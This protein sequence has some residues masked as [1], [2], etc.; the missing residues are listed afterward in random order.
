MVVAGSHYILAEN[1]V[2]SYF[3]SAKKQNIL[4]TF[5]ALWWEVGGFAFRPAQPVGVLSCLKKNSYLATDAIVYAPNFQLLYHLPRC[6]LCPNGARWAYSVYQSRIW[7]LGRRF[8]WYRFCLLL[9]HSAHLNTQ[10]VQLEK[11]HIL[12]VKL[13]PNGG[14]TARWSKRLYWEVWGSRR[15]GFQLVPALAAQLTSNR[16]Q[17]GCI[18]IAT[19]LA[20]KFVWLLSGL[21]PQICELFLLTEFLLNFHQ[22]LLAQH[23]A[24]VKIIIS[25][26]FLGKTLTGVLYCLDRLGHVLSFD[27]KS[28][29]Q[30]SRKP[31]DLESQNFKIF[32]WTSIPT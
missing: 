6:V 7:M 1:Y 27:A 18:K 8:D 19:L 15:V 31:F 22:P 28:A 2:T 9:P 23:C 3:W 13:R 29:P 24:K 20:A 25:R 30:I 21:S 12:Q 11:G 14:R 32:A 26:P 17:I 5:V 16:P 4:L 10:G